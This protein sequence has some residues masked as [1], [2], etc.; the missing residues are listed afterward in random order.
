M[1]KSQK[2]LIEG[3][4][5]I[6]L[7]I[8]LIFSVFC[9]GI[10]FKNK[11][12]NENVSF[13]Y[14]DI[15]NY[16]LNLSDKASLDNYFYELTNKLKANPFYNQE[17]KIKIFICDSYGLYTFLSNIIYKSIGQTRT[18]GNHNFI[19]INKT[20]FS[21]KKVISQNKTNNIRNFESVVLHESTHAFITK[22]HSLF[23]RF[24]LPAWKE[25]G[26]CE[27]IASESS[28]KIETGLQNFL[29]D[30]SDNS[31]SYKYFEYRLAVLYMKNYE[32]LSYEEIIK[33]KRN[34]SEILNI[35]KQIPYKDIELWFY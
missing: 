1:K 22:I 13:Y 32:Q 6:L 7:V 15:E 16:N 25:E 34:L 28:Y 5:L 33:D 35:I 14:N 19:V 3:I 23:N 26:I 24:S 8:Y 11:Y 31:K 4:I 30:K 9:C 12:T 17:K 18:F 21:T 29:S 10:F 20:D 2:K 27:S